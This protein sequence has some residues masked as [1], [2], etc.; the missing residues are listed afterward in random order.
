MLDLREW[1][2]SWTGSRWKEAIGIG[3]G[4]AQLAE[5]IRL[6]TRKGSLSPFCPCPVLSPPFCRC[7]LSETPGLSPFLR[8]SRFIHCTLIVTALLGRLR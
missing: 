4:E 5:R 7:W 8:G 2:T 6:A 1:R 3:I